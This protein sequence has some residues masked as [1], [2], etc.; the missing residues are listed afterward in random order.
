MGSVQDVQCPFLPARQW[1]HLVLHGHLVDY[2]VSQSLP[3]RVSA[4]PVGDALHIPSWLPSLRT[5]RDEI[6]PQRSA[7]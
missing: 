7:P 3:S 1:W 5:L 4:T 6:T 2:I